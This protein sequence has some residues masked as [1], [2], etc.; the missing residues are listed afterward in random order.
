MKRFL[1]VILV[2]VMILTA[3]P[4]VFATGDSLS[5]ETVLYTVCG[6]ISD[7]G[8]YL[9]VTVEMANNIKGLWGSAFCL[10]Y[11][12]DALRPLEASF[13]N[14]DVWDNDVASID[15]SLL[16]ADHKVE[17]LR[18]MV[19]LGYTSNTLENAATSESGTVAILRFEVIDEGLEHGIE[20][21]IWNEDESNHICAENGAIEAVPFEVEYDIDMSY[22]A[23]EDAV[24]YTVNG[25]RTEGGKYLDVSID[26]SNNIN[27]LWGSIFYL[28]YNTEALAPVTDGIANGDVWDSSMASIE[29]TSFGDEHTY[30][31]ARNTICLYFMANGIEN[32]AT[33]E[34]GTVAT[35]RFEVLDESLDHGIEYLI[36][37]TDEEY[38]G[39]SFNHVCADGYELVSVPYVIEYNVDMAYT[40][41]QA[42]KGDVNNDGVINTLDM[43]RMK[44]FIKTIVEPAEIERLASDING[45]GLINSVDTFNLSYRILY[46]RWI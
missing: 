38:E 17:E 37:D 4:E 10:K 9:D 27:G 29:L 25:I 3:I 39:D 11:N 12:T 28:K 14:G 24:C 43:F 6:R 34:S 22:T 23:P 33:A 40:P 13:T 26:M 42:V 20:Y 31:W 45:D 16:S 41:P 19:Y 18:S 46:G 7:D 44:L 2:V 21:L 30:E 15:I 35:V 8:K 32:V 36:W 1:S 5:D